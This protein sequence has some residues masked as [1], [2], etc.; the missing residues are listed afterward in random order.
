MDVVKLLIEK[1]DGLDVNKA[2][3]VRSGFVIA[4]V[5][6]VWGRVVLCSSSWQWQ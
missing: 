6:T 1:C 2:G 4:V 5:C 3:R